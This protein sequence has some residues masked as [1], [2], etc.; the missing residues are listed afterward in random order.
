MAFTLSEAAKATGRS[1]SSVHRA[2]ER[3]RLSGTRDELGQ[4]RIEPAELFRVFP[5]NGAA[6]RKTRRS[7][8]AEGTAGT[9]VTAVL[10]AKLEAA[11]RLIDELRGQVAALA[12]E[13]ADLWRRL[14][15]K[16]RLMLELING[17]RLLA[18]PGGLRAWWQRL[19]RRE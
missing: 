16:D 17:Q 7:E 1:K 12:A 8:T 18:G 13:K 19:W 9:P 11:E 10:E 3:G 4:W 6:E 5:R 14:D 2:L 15:D